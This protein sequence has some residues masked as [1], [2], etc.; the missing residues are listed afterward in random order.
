MTTCLRLAVCLALLVE[1]T[2]LRCAGWQVQA[3]VSRVLVFFP[4]ICVCR[5]RLDAK[6]PQRTSQQFRLMQRQKIAKTTKRI[7]QQFHLMQCDDASLEQTIDAEPEAT[8]KNKL[9]NKKK[10]PKRTSQRLKMKPPQRTSQ[11]F[12][13]MW[14]Q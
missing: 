14:R 4:L 2:M 8:T 6:P 1:V 12:H 10:L 11:Q 5:Q 7:S 13:L 9:P 3:A